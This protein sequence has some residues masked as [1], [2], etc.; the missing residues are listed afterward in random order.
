[1][2]LSPYKVTA[3]KRVDSNGINTMAGASVSVFDETAEH[4]VIYTSRDG[5]TQMDNPFNADPYGEREFWINPGIYN[6][7]VAGGQSWNV[8]IGG[9]FFLQIVGDIVVDLFSNLSI[10]APTAGQVVTTKGNYAIGD[11][12]GGQFVAMTGSPTPNGTTISASSTPGLYFQMIEATK[13]LPLVRPGVSTDSMYGNVI[14]GNN[15]IGNSGDEWPLPVSLKDATTV[16]RAL[17]GEQSNYHGFSDKTVMS[18]MLD[19]GGYAGFDSTV[20]IRG[21]NHQ[22]HLHSFQDRNI[23]D[24]ASPGVVDLTCGFYSAPVIN[25][26]GTISERRGA[27]VLD[28][29]KSGGAVVT[30]NVGYYAEDMV[31]GIAN[32]SFLSKQ[33]AGYAYYAPNGGRMYNKGKAGFGIDPTSFAYTVSFAG[34]GVSAPLGFLDTDTSYGAAIGTF[35]N[36]EIN[37]FTDGVSR[38]KVHKAANTYSWSSS[39][40]NQSYCGLS[41]LRM[42]GGYTATNFITT[43]DEREKTV[44]EGGVDPAVMRATAKI[45]FHQYQR[46]DSIEIKADGAR[47]HFG[48]LAQQVKEAFES[49]GLNAF[50]YGLLCYDKW[51]DQFEQ[52]QTNKDEIIEIEVS[53]LAPVMIDVDQEVQ[54]IRVVGGVKQVSIEYRPISVE[55]G[56]FETVIKKK[57]M[58]AEP[59]F[60]TVQ[61][62]FAGD[63]YGIRYEELLA[64]KCAHADRKIQNIQNTLLI[65]QKALADVQ[66]KLGKK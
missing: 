66:L 38:F 13:Y 36:D 32:V 26:S 50:D 44:R 54:V 37:L 61:T 20:T 62:Q 8:S 18:S 51:D 6:V 57:S 46:N 43:S 3:L 59:T 27:C 12:G 65:I 42:A 17:T 41:T 33:T 14:I 9:E 34:S 28:I 53:E 2:S 4:A 7:S 10:I 45:N 55:S 31:G 58:R 22:N 39:V 48:V 52:V 19:A 1:M 23:F 63:R 16:S 64:L 11:G 40:D 56:E 24:I 47:W 5:T 30:N 60:E 35:G 21:A 25:N 15:P 49:E 29:T